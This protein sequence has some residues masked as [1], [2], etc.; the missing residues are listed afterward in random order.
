MNEPIILTF[1]VSKG[2]TG[3]SWWALNIAAYLGRLGY[4]PMVVDFNTRATAFS[5]YARAYELKRDVFHHAVKAE[6]RTVEEIKKTYSKYNFIIL[7]TTQY[8]D[9]G[10]V[11]NAWRNCDCMLAPITCDTAD[12]QDFALALDEL[13]KLSLKRPVLVLP[14]RVPVLKNAMLPEEF[15]MFLEMLSKAGCKIPPIPKNKYLDYNYRLQ[16]LP[17]RNIYFNSEENKNKDPELAM[18]D[19]AASETFIDKF[20]EHGRWILSEIKTI[21]GT[22]PPINS[23]KISSIS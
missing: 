17:I 23:V 10:D 20:E 7:D 19:R 9:R 14:S 3:K 21:V 5:E 1:G 15:S 16:R 18:E 4:W 13:R 12:F 22:L 2:G 8:P 11:E 6:G